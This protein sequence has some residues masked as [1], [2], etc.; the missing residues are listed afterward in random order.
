MSVDYT[1]I[2]T[3]GSAR[4]SGARPTPGAVLRVA[5]WLQGLV[6]VFE[7]FLELGE[8]PRNRVFPTKATPG[9]RKA[10]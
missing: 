4:V 7:R 2:H 10:G 9:V 5:A 1:M 6:R 3:W 8:P